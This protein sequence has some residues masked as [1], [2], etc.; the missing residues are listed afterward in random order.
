MSNA[1]PRGKFVWHELMTADAAAAA[2]FYPKVVSWKTEPFAGM[3]SYTMWVA[4][5]GPVG[6]IMVLPADDTSPA[7]WLP[8]IGVTDVVEAVASAKVL[9]AHV[10]KDTTEIPNV[11]TFAVLADPQGV[12][13][14]IYK[15]SS[16]GN[17]AGGADA[18]DFSWH[19]L[20]TSDPE[21]ALNFYT[22]LFGWGVG[23]RH[24]MGEPVGDYLLFLHGGEQYGGIYKAMSGQPTGWLCYVKVE[25]AGK[26]ANAAKAAGGRVT[27]GPVE[28]P[29]GSW[30]AQIMDP[31]GV[32][33]AVHEARIEAKAPPPPKAAKPKAPKPAKPSAPA[34]EA[35]ATPASAEKSAAPAK[36]AAAAKPARAPTKAPASAPPARPAVKA[37]A[38]AK[39]KVAPARAVAKKAAG[40]KVAGKKAVT[41]KTAAKKSAAG[42]AAARSRVVVKKGTA[43]KPARK[44]KK[45]PAKK[46]AKR[47]AARKAVPRRAKAKKRR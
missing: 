7:R 16:P 14:A 37:K 15:S 3:D 44:A 6:G 19:E 12:E 35:A 32:T 33:F 34:P 9:G 13:F 45:K 38:K 26:A 2:S 18:G 30:I 24:P 42:K 43:A 27:N 11:G 22:T 47:A 31:E 21:A 23:P 36:P 28:V 20:A 4:K 17:G 25:D 10:L 5:N 29:G 1:D 40:K 39:K 8:Y 46:A 41:K